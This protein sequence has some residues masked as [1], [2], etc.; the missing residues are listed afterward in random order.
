MGGDGRLPERD[1]ERQKCHGIRVTLRCEEIANIAET[2]MIV[3]AS[4]WSALAGGSRP[5]RLADLLDTHGDGDV[6]LD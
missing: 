1:G 2:M 3:D 4:V 6:A 5:K